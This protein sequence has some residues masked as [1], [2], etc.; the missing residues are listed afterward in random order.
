MRVDRKTTVLSVIGVLALLAGPVAAQLPPFPQVPQMP[1]DE[2]ELSDPAPET[3]RRPPTLDDL[4]ERLANAEDQEEAVGVAGLIERRLGKSGSPTADLLMR[5]A[6]TSAEDGNPDAAIELADRVLALE[7]GWADAWVQQ[8]VFFQMVDDADMAFGNLLRAL[9]IEP[10]H[11]NAMEFLGMM[12]LESEQYE[13]A[14]L[15][16]E[17]LLRVFPFSPTAQP[18]V[19]ALRRELNGMGI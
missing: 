5:R 11:F 6:V 8:A 9:Q 10:R 2:P 4:F 15:V 14:L 19:E 16:Y 3:K 1:Q 12:L 18:R 17:R 7:P 13:A